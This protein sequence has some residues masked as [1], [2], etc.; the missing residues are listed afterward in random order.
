[1]NNKYPNEYVT[2]FQ[3]FGFI[4]R[5]R[6]KVRSLW[7]LR[8]YHSILI[9]WVFHL[10]WTRTL[11]NSLNYQIVVVESDIHAVRCWAL[12]SVSSTCWWHST[13]E[14]P[15]R[16]RWSLINCQNTRSPK[17]VTAKECMTCAS[18]LGYTPSA[19]TVTTCSATPKFILSV[20]ITRLLLNRPLIINHPIN[21]LQKVV[22]W[23]RIL[24][25][26][27][28]LLLIFRH[29][30]SSLLFDKNSFWTLDNEWVSFWVL[31]L[32]A[33][34]GTNVNILSSLLPLMS[35]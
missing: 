2:K 24:N 8:S 34:I 20:G 6:N 1:M 12:S 31:V 5:N 7:L 9:Q 15:L 13:Q 26:G 21:Q 29:C 28:G 3:L 19:T 14:R 33:P 10:F 32:W 27:T 17:S 25:K 30:N 18:T 4:S 35:V 23:I 22:Y 11:S 16:L